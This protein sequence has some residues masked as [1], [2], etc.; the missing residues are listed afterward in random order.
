MNNAIHFSSAFI[1]FTLVS[2]FALGSEFSLG[3]I[4][5]RGVVSQN[6]PMFPL[7]VSDVRVLVL[8]IS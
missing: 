6:V 1:I 8:V 5:C 2:V 4:F 3:S 7:I